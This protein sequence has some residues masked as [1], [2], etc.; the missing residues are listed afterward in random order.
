MVM[1]D[2]PHKLWSIVGS[3]PGHPNRENPIF[4]AYARPVAILQPYPLDTNIWN[5]PRTHCEASGDERRAIMHQRASGVTVSGLIAVSPRP[6]IS[7]SPQAPSQGGALLGS[8]SAVQ[9]AMRDSFTTPLETAPLSYY[10]LLGPG[11]ARAC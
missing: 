5:R 1:G 2:H 9:C 10:K 6:F 4:P 7:S 11:R 8:H 3:L